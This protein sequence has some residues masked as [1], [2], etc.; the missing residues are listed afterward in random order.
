[1]RRRWRSVTRRAARPFPLRVSVSLSARYSRMC[2]HAASAHAQSRGPLCVVCAIHVHSSTS[3]RLDLFRS[4]STGI[5]TA[6]P[7]HS[8]RVDCPY[9]SAITTTTAAADAG[10]TTRTSASAWTPKPLRMSPATGAHLQTSRVWTP[11]LSRA[12]GPHHSRASSVNT[13]LAAR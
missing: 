2:L 5:P 4:D 3:R 12:S 11:A 1:M 8:R 13:V 7:P 9:Y 10:T 6:P